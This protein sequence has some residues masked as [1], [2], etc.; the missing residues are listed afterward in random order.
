MPMPKINWKSKVSA[1]VFWPC[2]IILLFTSITFYMFKE[3]EKAL[4][5]DTQRQ[6]VETI[7]EKKEVEN[8]LIETIKAKE[9]VVEEVRVKERQIKLVLDKLEKEIVSRRIAEIQLILATKEKRTLR[10][11]LRQLTE[12]PETIELEKVVVKAAPVLVA[13]VLMVNKEQAFIV[14]DLG[15]EDN[16]R[17]GDT[18]SV[19]RNGEFIG[20]A[21]VEKVQEKVSAAAILPQWQDVEF[22]ENDE[23]RQI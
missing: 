22:K 2:M 23:V 13:K 14:V 9:A 19:C 16:L 18:L 3:K 17:I 10:T 8:E 5:I 7:M 12:T 6:L 21:E 15:R 11:R 1:K 4:R 20:R